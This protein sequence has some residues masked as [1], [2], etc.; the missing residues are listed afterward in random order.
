MVA[1]KLNVG[2][3]LHVSA[4]PAILARS[5]ELLPH[6]SSVLR[7]GDSGQNSIRVI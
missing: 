1:R 5:L 2:G 4:V 6:P 3:K 7:L